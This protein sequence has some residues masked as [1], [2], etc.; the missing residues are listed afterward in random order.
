MSKTISILLAIAAFTVAGVV[1]LAPCGAVAQ[2]NP[3]LTNVIPE[4]ESAQVQAT[5]AAINPT[6]REV[7]LRG[8]SGETV[9]MTAGPAVRLELLKVGDT[10]DAQYYRSVAWEVV[11][12]S[13]GN[14]T[15]A[16]SNDQVATLLSRPA[17]APGGAAV[18]VIKISGTVVGI[19]LAAHRLQIVS[20]GG[21]EIHI[22]DVTNATRQQ[23]MS[24]LKVGD[25]VTAVVSEALAI[26]IQP[27]AKRM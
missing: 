24:R 17:H 12:A 18:Q 11:G 6:T 4:S 22:V 25:T 14:G 2:R 26:T 19:D 20:P 16:E 21:G 3:V 5:I 9:T 10:V 8:A 23:M 7:A 13:G 27:A 1:L 15:P